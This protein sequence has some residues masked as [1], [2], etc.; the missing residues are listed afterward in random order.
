MPSRDPW[1]RRRLY[2][3]DLYWQTLIRWTIWGVRGLAVPTAFLALLLAIDGGRTGTTTEGIAYSRSLDARVLQPDGIS[4]Q[5]VRLAPSNCSEQREGRTYLF[6]DRPGCSASV[7]V[8]SE[9]GRAVGGRDTLEVVRTPLFGWVRAVQR[10]SDGLRDQTTALWTIG[11]YVLLGLLPL[12]SFGRSFA[13]SP[14]A[15]GADRRFMMYVVPALLAEA[16][17]LHLFLQLFG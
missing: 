10:P 2:D 6:A 16:V 11:G 13:Q 7:A 4:L 17:Y 9:F 12:L 1:H 8:D 5:L 15:G 14:V 3:G